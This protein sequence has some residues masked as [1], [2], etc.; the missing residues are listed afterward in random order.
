MSVIYTQTCISRLCK[1][2][3]ITNTTQQ[4]PSPEAGS[5]SA[6]ITFSASSWNINTHQKAHKQYGPSSHL[7]R[8]SSRSTFTPSGVPTVQILRDSICNLIS[9]TQLTDFPHLVFFIM[10]SYKLSTNY[11][12]NHSI[13]PSTFNNKFL[14]I[15]FSLHPSHV[16]VKQSPCTP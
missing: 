12:N 15:S 3:T 7:H 2:R 6:G 9:C 1:S 14:S 5:H 4:S 16:R 8:I 11:R 13:P 10:H